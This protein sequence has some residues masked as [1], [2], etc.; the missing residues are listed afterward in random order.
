MRGKERLFRA[1]VP[2]TPTGNG[3]F[4]SIRLD[5]RAGRPALGAIPTAWGFPVDFAFRLGIPYNADGLLWRASISEHW[6]GGLRMSATTF[7]TKPCPACGRMARILLRYMGK[8]VCCRHCGRQFV[9]SDPDMESAANQ[10]PLNYWI[11]FTESPVM[12]DI[13]PSPNVYRHP[14]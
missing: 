10:D 14:R 2:V 11:H 13:P 4:L 6:H 1:P 5:G 12:D 7:F 9:A 8:P 3:E